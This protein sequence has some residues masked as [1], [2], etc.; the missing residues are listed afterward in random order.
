MHDI[1]RFSGRKMVNLTENGWLFRYAAP[2]YVPNIHFFCTVLRE[3]RA[4]ATICACA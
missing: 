4:E 2:F 1:A 3:V